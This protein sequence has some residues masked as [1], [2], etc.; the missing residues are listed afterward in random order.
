MSDSL[1]TGQPAK[2]LRDPDS[3]HPTKL[4][5]VPLDTAKD[6]V[7]N[8]IPRQAYDYGTYTA[9][10][11]P[12]LPHDEPYGQWA[13]SSARYEWQEDYGDVAPRD[14][15]LEKMLFGQESDEPSG[16][17]ID[18]SKY[19]LIIP[20]FWCFKQL[21]TFPRLFQ[22]KVDIEGVERPEPIADVRFTSCILP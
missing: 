15:R 11:S 2:G 3:S 16:A 1:N 21:L 12:N 6:T 18:F 19:A 22:L 4:Q 5:S 9:A 20:P 14:E 13:A 17:G 8:W 10:R 7:G